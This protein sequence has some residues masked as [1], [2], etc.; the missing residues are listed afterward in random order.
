MAE[1]IDDHEVDPRQAIGEAA[2]TTELGLRLELVDKINRIEEARL[3]SAPDH[4]AGD[5]DRKVALAG[6]DSPDRDHIALVRKEQ[7]VARRTPPRR[8]QARRSA[9][10]SGSTPSADRRP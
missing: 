6:A 7:A 4:F 3:A 1:F 5:G 9:P 10:P 2:G 8:R